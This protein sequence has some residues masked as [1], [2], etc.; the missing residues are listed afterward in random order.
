MQIQYT[1]I[2]CAIEALLLKAQ[3]LQQE[4]VEEPKDR[5]LPD[6]VQELSFARSLVWSVV[7]DFVWHF[8]SP[9]VQKLL[10]HIAVL[11]TI[12]LFIAYVMVSKWIPQI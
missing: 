8:L 1:Q 4:Q 12:T 11:E 5:E 3:I 10:G 9:P 6:S 2:A 7:W